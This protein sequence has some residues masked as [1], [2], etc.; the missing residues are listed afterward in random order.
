MPPRR[1]RMHRT[2]TSKHL[3]LTPRDLEILKALCRYR[4]LRSTYLHAFVG[5]ESEKRFKERLGDLFHEGYLDR[6]TEQWRFADSRCLPVVHELGKGGREVLTATAV[7]VPGAI[8]WLRNGPYRQFEHSLMTCEVLASIELEMRERPDLRFIPWPEILA[9]APEG[10]RRADRPYQLPAG[11]GLAS[12]TPDAIFGIEY[13]RDG[14]K[15]FRFFAFE[16]DRAT[17]P[18]VRTSGNGTS[19]LS[20]LASYRYILARDSHRVRLGIPNL[21]V[22]TVT[23]DQARCDELVRRFDEQNG[24][25]PQYLF[26]AV[27]NGFATFARPLQALLVQPWERPGLPPLRID[28]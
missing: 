21:L 17:M 7:P 18:I 13:Q 4:H 15:V 8:M 14:R 20:K 27:G 1:S 10:T 19:Y 5:G 12:V 16:A 24:E 28:Q 22:L 9:K 2:R 6:P 11:D 3:A 23:T 25:G 26:R